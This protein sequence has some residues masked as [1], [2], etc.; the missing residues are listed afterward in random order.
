MSAASVS[1]GAEGFRVLLS[2]PVLYGL[3]A[4]TVPAE[5]AER[6]FLPPEAYMDIDRTM[7]RPVS[8]ERRRWRVEFEDAR[9]LYLA[10]SA[11]GTA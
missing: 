10:S 3:D 7:T 4:L 5:V 8:A 11:G 1:D 2:R 6:C 9:R